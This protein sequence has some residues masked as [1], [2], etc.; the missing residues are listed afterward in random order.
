M[1]DFLQKSSVKRE[2][3]LRCW[4]RVVK[5]GWLLPFGVQLFSDGV[6]LVLFKNVPEYVV[7]P[8]STHKSCFVLTVKFRV[9]FA[10]LFALHMGSR[11]FLF[12]V[13]KD[14]HSKS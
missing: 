4:T 5:M 6:V 3:A 7:D 13:S 8:V 11:T 14:V 12:S 9:F 1:Y 2:A 10:H